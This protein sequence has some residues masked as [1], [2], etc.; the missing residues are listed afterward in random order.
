MEG[1][2]GEVGSALKGCAVEPG[3]PLE[4]RPL[5]PGVA[6][7]RRPAE[8]GVASEGRLAEDGNPLKGHHVEQGVALEDRP[9][10]A[11]VALEDGPEEHGVALEGRHVELGAR[12]QRVAVVVLGGSSKQTL[13]KS[14]G[15][16]H[17]ACIQSAVLAQALER[18]IEVGLGGVC[19]ALVTGRET[20]AVA[21]VIRACRPDNVVVCHVSI[22]RLP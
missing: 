15:D 10:E 8:H 3:F 7:E 16:R 1:C 2:P 13:K 12:Q 18:R 9:V 5:E 11:G 17:A 21:A 22:Y 20:N 19:P 14:L 6:L 4:G